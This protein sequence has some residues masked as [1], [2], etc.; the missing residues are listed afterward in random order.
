IAGPPCRALPLPGR[1]VGR[2]I[3]ATEGP[4]GS[5]CQ[6]DAQAPPV[7]F[8][9]GMRKNAQP[10]RTQKWNRLRFVAPHAIDRDDMNAPQSG[11]GKLIELPRN[12]G[13]ADGAAHPPPVRPGSGS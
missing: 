1:H 8:A 13:F 11:F 5:G 10:A 2:Y 4:A 9:D 6:V 7:G 3:R 12:V